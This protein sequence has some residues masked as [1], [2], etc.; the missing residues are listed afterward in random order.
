MTRTRRIG[1]DQ[2]MAAGT[3]IGGL[4][5]AATLSACGSSSSD[6][7][8]NAAAPAAPGST[9]AGTA[10]TTV[11]TAA[12]ALVPASIKSS[13]KLTFGV[14]SQWPPFAVKNPDGSLGGIEVDLAKQ[15]AAKLDLTASFTD[16]AFPSIVPGVVSGR[17]DIGA[18]ELGDTP[19]RRAQL[20]FVDYYAAGM[21]VLVKKGTTGIDPTNLCG[22]TVAVPTGS[23]QE[24][25]VTAFSSDCT[26]S[27]QPA[28]KQVVL[29][30][31]AQTEESVV[32][33]RAEAF[34]TD[35]A[36]AHYTTKVNQQ[37]VNVP[38]EIKSPPLNSGMAIK[39]DDPGLVS[40]VAKAVQDLM[41][42][43]SFAAD[44]KQYGVTAGLLK[45]ALVN[46]EAQ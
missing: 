7:S 5:L 42:D 35:D 41:D 40:A 37:L 2:R 4:L 19:E 26:K 15:I 24:Q 23:I 17:F 36:V 33:G 10:G 6:T 14:T 28:I 25:D 27:G 13:G 31:D 43:G 34:I 46:G 8:A 3:A 21:S 45:K 18:A 9:A 44:F 29:P 30:D 38:G 12:A 20:S 32:S 16:I 39:K 22:H 1:I 11:D